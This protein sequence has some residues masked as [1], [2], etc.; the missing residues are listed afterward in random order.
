MRFYVVAFIIADIN[1]NFMVHYLL[2]DYSTLSWNLGSWIYK[3]SSVS[4]L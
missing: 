4:S 2:L 3:V 1:I